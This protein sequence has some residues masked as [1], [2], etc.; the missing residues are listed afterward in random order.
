MQLESLEILVY[1][2]ITDKDL[3]ICL[4]NLSRNS[5]ISCYFKNDIYSKFRVF[6]TL[7]DDYKSLFLCF[8][9]IPLPG[10][11]WYLMIASTLHVTLL[12]GSVYISN[13]RG[14]FL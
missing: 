12:G 3:Y 11:S 6:P 9:C 5:L 14:D 1:L 4:N 2:H 8:L 13:S 10:K 7:E